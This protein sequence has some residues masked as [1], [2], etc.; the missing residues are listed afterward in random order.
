MKPIDRHEVLEILERRRRYGFHVDSR[1]IREVQQPGQMFLL[2]LETEA[3]F[4][5]LVW[6][7]VND[8][9]PLTPPG[10]PRTLRDCAK[11]LESYGWS[12]RQLCEAGYSWFDKCV[13]ID[14][15]FDYQKFGWLAVVPLNSHEQRE[16]PS[17]T[18]YI[19]DGV[20]KAIVLAKKLARRELSYKPV[21]ALLLTPRRR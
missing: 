10:Q 3:E 16:S 2:P 6:Q 17:G 12:F 1:L 21:E 14:Q 20:H 9:R 19:F 4:M 13:A 15:G 7:S 5:K 11:R 8:T 18:Y